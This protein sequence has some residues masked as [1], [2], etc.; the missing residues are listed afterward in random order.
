MPLY[1]V[2]SSSSSR[3]TSFWL[4]PFRLDTWRRTLYGILCF[5]VGALWFVLTIPG[6]VASSALMVTFIIGILLFL[7]FFGIARTAGRFERARVR[8]FLDIPIQPIDRRSSARGLMSRFRTRIRE[9]RTW[10][11][12]A[13][14]VL[15]LPIGFVVTFASLYPWVQT[16]YSLSYPIVFWNVQFTDEVWGGPSWIGAVSVH[17]FPGFITLFLAPWWVKGVTWLHGKFVESM[18]G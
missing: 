8:W 13:F 7:T 4:A 18:L 11:E 15:N 17:F 14:V 10:R 5:P 6:I 16:V 12:V 1:P 2:V 3:R 9:G